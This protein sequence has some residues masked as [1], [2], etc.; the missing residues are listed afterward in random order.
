MAPQGVY[1]AV[2]GRTIRTEG[3]L[4]GMRMIMVPSIR[5][6]LA[7]GFAPPQEDIRCGRLEHL[8]VGQME[9]DGVL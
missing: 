3:T 6:L 9:A 5:H 2:G 7:A 1:P 4:R 8:V